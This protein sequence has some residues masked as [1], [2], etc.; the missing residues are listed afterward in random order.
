MRILKLT[1]RVE[2]EILAR[3]QR[4]D[5]EA[6]RVA[7]RI[8]A[9]VRRRGDRA[10]LVW[11]RRFDR[12]RAQSVTELCLPLA[13]L[14]AARGTAA[15]RFLRAVEAA[16]RNI[17]CV[18]NQQLP[19][20]WKLRV[21]NG[22]SVAQQVRPLE[23]I[24]CYIPGGRAS[25]VSTLLMTVVP[26][27]VAGVPRI[28]VACPQPSPALL[29][30]ADLLG[31]RELVRVGGA[32]AIAA[33]AYG[34][35]SLPRVEK[36]FGPGN[37]YVTA[38]KQLVSRDCAIDLLAGPTELLVLA[39]RG[40]PDLIAAD[41]VAQAEHDPDGLVFFVTPSRRLAR[42]VRA[43]VAQQLWTLPE[44]NPAWRS[45]DHNGAILIAP[46]LKAAVTFANRFAPEHLS[47]P[48]GE[49]G[50]LEAIQSAGSVFLGPWSA[51]PLGDYATGSN[52]V[53]P[54]GGWAR[55]R[56]GL[57]AGDFVKPVAV[58]EVSREGLRRLAP[59]A[60]ELARAENLPAHARAVRLAMSAC[61]NRVQE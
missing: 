21:T 55:V 49:H 39:T 43:A 24:G 8:I 47:L 18:A 9:D 60:A 38:A 36:I 59:V 57:T 27:Q 48:G 41:M 11:A 12:V 6:E 52:H 13:E 46:N 30:T 20:P 58:Q 16:A 1:T 44:T 51:Q 10:L 45:L 40:S 42:Q 2:T 56:G 54:T 17:R 19:R 23:S 31:V 50:L 4:G 14:R 33:L 34:T 25:L 37:R 7:A 28:V 22:V 5:P 61:R 29:A 3:R 15:R 32:Q 53:L 26:A 35:E